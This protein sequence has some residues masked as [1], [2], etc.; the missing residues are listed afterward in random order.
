M[1]QTQLFFLGDAALADG[2]RLAGFEVI[3]DATEHDMEALLSKLIA[4]RS[5]AF[6]VLDHLLAESD[7]E[8]LQD[9][10][11]EGGRILLSQV[12]PL[13]QPGVMP[14]SVDSRI[15]QLLGQAG[16]GA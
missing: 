2:F 4:Q 16:E 13:H 15:A 9:V 12:P 1:Q 7:S 14:S 6:V 5:A 10:R 3:A 11:R 8:L